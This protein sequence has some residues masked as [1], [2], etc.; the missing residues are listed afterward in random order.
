MPPFHERANQS[1][2]ALVI[3]ALP[4]A[5]SALAGEALFGAIGAVVASKRKQIRRQNVREGNSITNAI[6]TPMHMLARSLRR[7]AVLQE[8]K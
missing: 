5:D 8:Q 2:R 4:Q 7:S 1:N 3:V 6:V